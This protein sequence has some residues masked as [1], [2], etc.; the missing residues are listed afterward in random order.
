MDVVTRIR[1][2]EA[3]QRDFAPGILKLQ[4]A[5]PSPLPRLVLWGLLAL[6][7]ITVVWSAFG[8]LDIIAVAQ[9][10][11]V[12][13]SYLQIVQPAES[14]IVKELLVREGDVVSAGQVLARMDK[15]FSEADRQALKNELA[16]R[17]L[18]L[19][20]I[21]A[22][23]AGTALTQK[24]DDPIELFAQ[25]D[26]QYRARRQAFLDSLETERATLAKAEQDR[27]AARE[28]ESKLRQQLPI[29]REQEEAFD[30]LTREG[31]A[32]RLLFLE[33][34]RDRIE[35][36]QDLKAQEFAIESL[37]ASVEQ[38]RKRVAQLQSSYRQALQNE[39][40]ETEAQYAKLE[41]DWN[42]HDARHELLELRAPQ[43]GIVKDLATHTAGSV[44]QPGTV[45]MTLV[46]TN[47]PMQAE[48]WVTHDDAGFVGTGR[49]AK[50]K[51]ATYPFQKYGMI[52]GQV[53]RISPDA[54]D[55]S[56][57]RSDRRAGAGESPAAGSGYRTLVSL[58]TP[59]LEADGKRYPLTPGMQV[60]AEINLGTRT[61]LEY[62]LSPVQRTLHE[63]GRER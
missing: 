8:R 12:P 49:A 47:D 25:V 3:G 19:R 23:L 6:V 42:K 52:D 36:E 62:V 31:Y 10:R 9:G 44:L 17:S 46:P 28:I 30:R 63:A 4:D 2:L 48:V 5:S 27:R 51:L 57:A 39:R 54:S 15:R 43:D 16:Q 21:D 32:G 38:S 41:Q 45:L 40:V 22:E 29:Y 50:L 58:N 34:Q 26:A 20:R 59:Y 24:H 61:V 35:K 55:V 11:I 60:T 14:G 53:R 18:Q 13:Q 56:D 1:T 33:K 7:A 37:N